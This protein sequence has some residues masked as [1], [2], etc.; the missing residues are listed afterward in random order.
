MRGGFLRI[1]LWRD[2]PQVL[3]LDVCFTEG[4]GE[5]TPH[6]FLLVRLHQNEQPKLCSEAL[7]ASVV[8]LQL[9]SMAGFVD[10]FLAMSSH[11][12]RV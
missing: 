3:C 6:T 2:D 9:C 10:G 7:I 8:C 12:L 1:V 11:A 5:W 4:W